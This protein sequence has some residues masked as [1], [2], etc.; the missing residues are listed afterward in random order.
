M[1]AVL[2]VAAVGIGV[3]TNFAVRAIEK[4]LA[5]KVL[6]QEGHIALMVQELSDLLRAVETASLEGTPERVERVHAALDATERRLREVRGTYKLDTLLHASAMHA[7]ASPA[8]TDIRRWLEDGVA[9]HA[10]TSEV[11]LRLVHMRA[12]DAYA[13]V[14]G[15]YALSRMAAVDILSE[16]T[17]KL[18]KLRIGVLATL[19]GI[20][21]IAGFVI[22]LAARQRRTEN[23][24]RQSEAKFRAV[25]DHA[26][27]AIYLKDAAG[28]FLMASKKYEDWYSAGGP[29]E[30]KTV[31]DVFATKFADRFAAQDREV[32]DSGKPI[33]RETDMPLA[34]GDVRFFLVNKFPVTNADGTVV[35]IGGVNADI[36]ARQRAEEALRVAVGQQAAIAELGQR[37]LAE[38]DLARLFE[39]TVTLVAETLDV[40]Y[41]KI[42][43]PLPD[44]T[45]LLLRAGVGWTDGLVG[46]AVVGMGADS[47]AGFTLQSDRPVIVDDLRTETRFAGPP[48]L[49]DHGV[50]SGVSV[51]I[52]E[53]GQPFGV[54]GVHTATTRAFTPDDVSFLQT[55]ANVL[56]SAIV[57]KRAEEERRRL[58]EHF[59][60]I[61]EASPG[62]AAISDPDTGEHFDVNDSWLSALGYR[63]DEVIGR[64]A[65][66]LGVWDD[67][68][69]R[70]A[71]VETLR[72][73]GRIRGYEARL[74]AKDGAARD[75]LISGEFIELHGQPRLLL[76]G[77]DITERKRTEE[78]LRHAQKMEAVGQ[79]TG[80]VAHD[81]NN[82]LNIIL[83][84]LELLEIGV[85]D[86]PTQRERIARAIRAT[87]RG[88]A[89]TQRLLAF[90]RRQPLSPEPT[91]VNALIEGLTNMLGRTL[92]EMIE[93]EEVLCPDPWR[94]LI[95]RH[96]LENAI[97]NLAV[98][99]RDAM[100]DGGTLTIE[101]SNVVLDADDADR[102]E[103]VAP[104]DYVLVAVSDTGAGMEPEVRDKVFEPFFTTKEV[105]KG[106]GLGLSMIY[107]FIKQSNG[108]VS[109]DSGIGQGTTVKLYLRRADEEKGVGT[110]RAEADPPAGGG[111]RVLMVEDNPDVREAGAAMLRQS[112]YQVVEAADGAEALRHLDDGEPFDL[113]FTDIIL[114][115]GMKGTQLAVE[116]QRKQP[117]LK[118][119]HT[120]GYAADAAVRDSRPGDGMKLITKPYRRMDLIRT[121][122]SVL[123]RDWT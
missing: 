5:A 19:A 53:A 113:L 63:R 30:G 37:A 86:D 119:L 101:T 74:R 72:A 81:F 97:V 52:G 96:Q 99:A 87:E 95:D 54:L 20:A 18:E 102:F 62:L 49:H 78:A 104:G 12:R 100:P 48:L 114:P 115:G 64:T 92:G 68:A 71:V 60:K 89:L 112:G 56:A 123:Q 57:R 98:N 9:G 7:T 43:E 14:R 122:Q 10:G 39:A 120:T 25:A 33:E 73:E 32:L 105:G 38:T 109:V 16:Q 3:Y 94:T 50:V 117:G 6:K 27:A 35:G 42:L 70:A 58:E 121:V 29:L 44:G 1:V 90:S 24:L 80:G 45:A 11:V 67:F 21:V 110:A 59:A 17:P 8:L 51:T 15:Q 28:K 36:T 13:K 22:I 40:E 111:E 75:F 2:L 84:S 76:I 79:L 23:A 107:G 88:A 66:E 103:E 85:G 34:N 106:S 4:G 77:H 46:H 31:H 26:P 91:N 69:D 41:C 55:V 47:Q 82:L 93:I 65:F 61:F 83:N 118:V 108:H 116:A